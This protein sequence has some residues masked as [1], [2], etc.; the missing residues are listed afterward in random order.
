MARHFR[1]VTAAHG[2]EPSKGFDLL[3]AQGLRR[4]RR[5]VRHGQAP[6]PPGRR[7]RRP[8]RR[9]HLHPRPRRTPAPGARGGHPL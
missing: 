8:A 6:H 7:R 4:L 5:H 1:R 2:K 9:P 3:A